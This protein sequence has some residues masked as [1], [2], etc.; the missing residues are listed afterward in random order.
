M[1]ARG[2]RACGKAAVEGQ[3]LRVT[4]ALADPELA[5]LLVDPITHPGSVPQVSY[6]WRGVIL[7]L[8]NALVAWPPLT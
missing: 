1:G 6:A 3:W 4:G 7:F 5:S 2:P 8:L